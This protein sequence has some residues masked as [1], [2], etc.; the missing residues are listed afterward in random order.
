MLV[1]GVI[2][3]L[4]MAEIAIAIGYVSSSLKIQT[5]ENNSELLKLIAPWPLSGQ[6][7][8]VVC[9]TIITVQMVSLLRRNKY[10]GERLK[11]NT[12]MVINRL[13]GYMLSTG[14]LITAAALISL[15]LFLYDEKALLYVPAYF[16]Q[17]RLYLS[18]NMSFLNSRKNLRKN[19]FRLEAED[20]KEITLASMQFHRPDEQS[21]AYTKS[22][23]ENH[24]E[25]TDVS[26]H[27]S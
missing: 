8:Y 14:L 5:S 26:V 17:I 3:I 16:I 6:V 7:I 27:N 4:V 18:S 1:P 13:V 21:V 23:S 11:A 22:T 24:T 19:L 15:S 25:V 12:N 10:E 20:P 2:A 9:D